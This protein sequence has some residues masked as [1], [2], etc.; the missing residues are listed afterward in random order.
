[1]AALEASYAFH[2]P[3]LSQTLERAARANREIKA[4]QA[5]LRAAFI[6][7]ANFRFHRCALTD[8][9]RKGF[10]DGAKKARLDHQAVNERR[11]RNSVRRNRDSAL[12]SDEASCVAVAAE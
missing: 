11:R 2:K 6:T 7:A 5:W 9:E 8:E 1:M 12:N 3:G 4:A 10:C